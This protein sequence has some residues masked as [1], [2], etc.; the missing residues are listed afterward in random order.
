[1]GGAKRICLVD[2]AADQLAAMRLRRRSVGVVT[3]LAQLAF[4]GN[5][6]G[7][8]LLVVMDGMTGDACQLCLGVSG[9]EIDDMTL[10]ALLPDGF[11]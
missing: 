6:N 2:G 4:G 5:E 11:R 8:H 10:P 1:M 7:F 3:T 9:A